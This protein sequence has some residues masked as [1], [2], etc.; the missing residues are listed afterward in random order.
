MEGKK[1]TPMVIDQAIQTTVQDSVA[2]NPQNNQIPTKPKLPKS[3]IIY[4]LI[5]VIVFAIGF[6]VSTLLIKYQID[7]PEMMK[8]V[9]VDQNLQQL[10][11]NK[12]LCGNKKWLKLLMV[13]TKKAKY[14][15]SSNGI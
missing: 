11:N 1:I 2:P 10:V 4:T 6:G 9:V 12:N 15:L 14:K 8:A 5:T 3:V 7:S 13:I